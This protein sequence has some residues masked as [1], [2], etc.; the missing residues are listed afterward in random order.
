MNVEELE[1]Q[2]GDPIKPAWERLKKYVESLTVRTTGDGA[3][4]HYSPR[5]IDVVF[6]G[7][8]ATY[9]G[10]FPCNLLRSGPRQYITVGVETGDSLV[11]GSLIPV[12]N[13][14]PID[15]VVSPTKTVV[16]PQL[17]LSAGP[18]KDLRSWVCLQAVVDL[19]TGKL[20]DKNPFDAPMTI[21]HRNDWDELDPGVDSGFGYGLESIAMLIWRDKSTVDRVEQIV[22]HQ[23]RH[24]YRP[25]LKAGR[26]GRHFFRGM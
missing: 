26:K 8:G 11:N 3:A 10:H 16:R 23:I 2:K 24:D 1:V 4:I 12:I 5:Q 25:P 17:D 15:G 18:N 7:D 13:N 6:E 14:T 19:K 22:M 9:T 20:D 21:T